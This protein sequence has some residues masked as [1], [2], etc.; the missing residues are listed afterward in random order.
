MFY[1][2]LDIDDRITYIF[3][4]VSFLSRSLQVL[5]NYFHS[6]I[7]LWFILVIYAESPLYAYKQFQKSIL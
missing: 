4:F 6:V 7:S 1:L 2:S 3:E 5:V